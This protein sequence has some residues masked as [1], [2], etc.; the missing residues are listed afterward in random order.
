[1]RSAAAPM[2]ASST[3]SWSS[4]P[5]DLVVLDVSMPGED[6][7][8]IA[9]RLRAAGT[10]PI[11]MLTALDHVVDRVVG[12]EVGADD[13]MTKPFDLRELR[14]RVRALLRRASGARQAG[15][16]SHAGEAH[17]VSFGK[18]V[19]DLDAHCLVSGEGEPLPLTSSEFDLL[20]TFAGN[21]NRVLSREKLLEETHGQS[22]DPFD[23]SID[24]R[25]TRVRKKVEVDPAKPQAIRTVRGAGYM[26]V[27]ARA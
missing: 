23:R 7:I 10:T 5:A 24:I 20:R 18:V 9:R 21:P 12:L 16:A 26:F 22:H 17:R 14:A 11:L 2:A 8:S 13:Y 27:P 15:A 25:V 19:L 1:M 4:Y 3:L 6:G